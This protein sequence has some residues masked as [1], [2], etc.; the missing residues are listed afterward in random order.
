MSSSPR[1][2]SMLCRTARMAWPAV[3]KLQVWFPKAPRRAGWAPGPAERSFEKKKPPLG[4]PRQTDSLCPACVKEV[5]GDILSGRRD[6][7]SL[8]GGRPGEIKATI[9]EQ[10]GRIIMEKHCPTHGRFEDVLSI[11]PAFLA[12]IERLFPG[13]DFKG[14]PTELRKH[15][16]S[17]I[18]YGRGS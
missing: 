2:S 7:A 1:M 3:E 10:S 18:Q 12:R 11:D 5:R 13:Y 4:W 14:L 9:R 16:S 8:V 6:L 17:S 15:G